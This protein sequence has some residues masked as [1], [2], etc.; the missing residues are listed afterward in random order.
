M[1]GALYENVMPNV[2]PVGGVV[3]SLG[4]EKGRRAGTTIFEN[5]G[6]GI[7]TRSKCTVPDGRYCTRSME[8]RVWVR[9]GERRSRGYWDV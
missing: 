5:L 8:G 1:V 7:T 9:A 3:S 6:D 2:M 4:I